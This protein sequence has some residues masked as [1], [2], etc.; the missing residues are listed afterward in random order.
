MLFVDSAV[1]SGTRPTE[2]PDDKPSLMQLASSGAIR[3]LAK[4]GFGWEP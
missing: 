1:L 4:S 2:E 3:R